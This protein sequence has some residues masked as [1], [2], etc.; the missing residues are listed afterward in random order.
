MDEVH[1]PRIKFYH[2]AS[3]STKVSMSNLLI[4]K[5]GMVVQRLFRLVDTNRGSQVSTRG[6]LP[7]SKK[8]IGP[9]FE[10]YADVL[11]PLKNLL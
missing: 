7:E 5:T 8:S 1:T 2:D 10:I 4:S 3:L 6:D 9:L 11:D